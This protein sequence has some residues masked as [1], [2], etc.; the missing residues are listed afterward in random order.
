MSANEKLT[1]FIT[2]IETVEAEKREVQD[3]IKEIYAEAKSEGFD[4]KIM[5]AV[6]RL[7]KMPA[8]QREEYQG[9][10]D[11]YLSALGG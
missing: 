5:R 11:T 1:S 2:R 3:Q 4:A 8:H 6:I 9:L 10:L 7:R